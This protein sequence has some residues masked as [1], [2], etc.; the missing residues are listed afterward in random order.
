[1]FQLDFSDLFTVSWQLLN[2]APLSQMTRKTHGQ[3]LVCL[4]WTMGFLDSACARRPSSSVTNGEEDP[5][6][7]TSLPQVAMASWTVLVHVVLAPLSQMTRKTHGQALVC[8]RCHRDNSFLDNACARRPSSSVT[9]DEEDLWSGTSLPQVDN[10]SLDSASALRPTLDSI[11]VY[12]YEPL[13]EQLPSLMVGNAPVS[14]D[15]EETRQG[16]CAPRVDNRAHCYQLALYTWLSGYNYNV[17]GFGFII[18]FSNTALRI[19][20][21]LIFEIHDPKLVKKVCFSRI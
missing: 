13:S 11:R 20:K 17:V 2:P 5:W 4:R 8:L 15:E 9:N 12:V 16:T 10:G 14:N 6:S 18:I 19:N 7:G 1:M 21:K 3:A